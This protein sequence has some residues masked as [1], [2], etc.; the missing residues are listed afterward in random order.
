MTVGSA[1]WHAQGVRDS[2]SRRLIGQPLLDPRQAWAR[3][4]VS[5]PGSPR[6]PVRAQLRHARGLR[7]HLVWARWCT[8]DGARAMVHA[9]WCTRDGVQ[10]LGSCAAFAAAKRLLCGLLRPGLAS[11]AGPGPAGRVGT[12][13]CFPC[14]VSSGDRTDSVGMRRGLLRGLVSFVVGCFFGGDVQGEPGPRDPHV[15]W[16][17][18]G[19]LYSWASGAAVKFAHDP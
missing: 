18:A 12:A 4:A 1:S 13:S 6:R 11:S 16:G 9:R 15:Q 5:T 3:P 2:Q 8:R 19:V 14:H 10:G 7:A 17:D